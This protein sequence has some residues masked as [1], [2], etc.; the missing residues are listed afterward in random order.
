MALLIL[1]HLDPEVDQQ[2]INMAASLRRGFLMEWEH[3]LSAG[4]TA[5][6]DHGSNVRIRCGF[7]VFNV[8]GG[9]LYCFVSVH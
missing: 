4:D 8:T 5:V 6:Q 3:T 2:W 1:E 9:T 7:T